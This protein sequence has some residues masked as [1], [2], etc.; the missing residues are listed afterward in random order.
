MDAFSVT[1]EDAKTCVHQAMKLH[2]VRDGDL[3]AKKLICDIT[4]GQ[5]SDWDDDE[6]K[7]M[8]YVLACIGIL[9]YNNY[10]EGEEDD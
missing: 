1:I 7:Q 3:L 8:Y 2:G 9:Q 6:I 4:C 10:T 5:E